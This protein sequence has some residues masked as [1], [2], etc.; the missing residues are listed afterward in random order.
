L[1]QTALV[2]ARVLLQVTEL[3]LTLL[4]ALAWPL[5]LVVPVI[6][7]QA[8]LVQLIPVQAIPAQVIPAQ[9]ALVLLI[10]EEVAP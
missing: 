8:I 5:T 6:L 10:P 1:V 3:W 2:G 7:V 9:V 4:A